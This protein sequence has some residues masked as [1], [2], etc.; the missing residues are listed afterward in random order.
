MHIKN[1]RGQSTVEYILLVTAVVA[2]II[3]LV[4]GNKSQFQTTLN[5]TLNTAISDMGT[6]VDA[7]S[8]SHAPSTGVSTAT[9]TPPYSVKVA[10]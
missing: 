2:V 3:V 7:L 10:P 8:A 6:G 9:G 5:T 4:A 1:K